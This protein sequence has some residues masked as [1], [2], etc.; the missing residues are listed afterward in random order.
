VSLECCGSSSLFPRAVYGSVFLDTARQLLYRVA[1]FFFVHRYQNGKNLP[2]DLKLYQTAIKYSTWSL[3]STTFS[4]PRPSKIYP[5]WYFW[6]LKK[7]SGNPAYVL[8]TVP[9]EIRVGLKILMRWLLGR[10]LFVFLGSS[11]QSSEI[12]FP[13]KCFS[14][15]FHFLFRLIWANARVARFLLKQ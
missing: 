12:N 13:K 4:I 8:F 15:S 2:N 9:S 14:D 10:N 6:F 1:R 3:N 5:N 7:P 11:W